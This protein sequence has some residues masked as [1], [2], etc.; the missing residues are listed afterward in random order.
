MRQVRR[1]LDR[2]DPAYQLTFDATGY[3]GN[4]DIARLTGPDA[5]DAVYIMGYHYRGSWSPSAGS[6]APLDNPARYD[7]ADTLDIYLARTTPDRVIL[8]VPY[9]GFAWSTT[10]KGIRSPVRSGRRFGYP[11]AILYDAAARL[12]I[13]K[14]RRYDQVEDVA[15]AV[16]RHTQCSGCGETWRQLYYDSP[17]ALAAKYDTVNERDLLGAG[18]WALGYEGERTELNDILREKFVSP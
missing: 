15:W 9:Y 1:A 17:K 7:V 18:I 12:A 16:W 6:I 5:A 2:V 14:G 13:D 4:Y 10:K 11:Q 3:V 8:G